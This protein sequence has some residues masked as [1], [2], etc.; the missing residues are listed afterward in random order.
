MAELQ[1]FPGS[2]FHTLVHAHPPDT[3]PSGSPSVSVRE[4]LTESGAHAVVSVARVIADWLASACVCVCVQLSPS[5]VCFACV[6]GSCV[7]SSRVPA[8]QSA[9][10]CDHRDQRHRARMSFTRAGR[11]CQ[12]E[13]AR[14]NKG[15]MKLLIHTNRRILFG[16]LSLNIFYYN[17][18]FLSMHFF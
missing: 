1:R 7:P 5:C 10:C 8:G 4:L 9:A 13:R 11:G 3:L 18:Y 14:N 6:C 15:P 16:V 17:Y 2:H 12:D